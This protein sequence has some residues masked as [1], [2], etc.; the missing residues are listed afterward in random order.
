MPKLHKLQDFHMHFRDVLVR[1]LLT[2]LGLLRPST[3]NEFDTPDLGQH[4]HD[5]T[6]QGRPHYTLVK[7]FVISHGCLGGVGWGF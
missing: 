2:V 3:S 5:K 4:L 6:K 1:P 7:A